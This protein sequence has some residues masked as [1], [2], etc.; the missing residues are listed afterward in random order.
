MILGITTT[1]TLHHELPTHS[2]LFFRAETE[3]QIEIISKSLLTRPLAEHLT[4]IA[5]EFGDLRFV[6]RQP[7]C[8]SNDCGLRLFQ[9]IDLTASATNPVASGKGFLSPRRI[10]NPI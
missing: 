8:D 3:N 6:S 5:T 2:I 7:G 1:T 9:L 4:P 10:E